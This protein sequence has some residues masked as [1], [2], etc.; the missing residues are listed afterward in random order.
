MK[1]LKKF[2]K[3]F[4]LNYSWIGIIIILIT[5]IADLKTSNQTLIQKTFIELFKTIGVSV[6]IASVFTWASESYEFIDKIQQLLKSVVVKRDF[7][8]N[9]D[10]ESKMDALK[11]IIKPSSFEKKIYANIEDYYDFYIRQTMEIANK[12]V[13]SDYS[14]NARIY[15][16]QVKNIIACDQT[17]NYRL[18]PNSNGYEKINV[19]FTESNSNLDLVQYVRVFKQ[20]NGV[21]EKK[22]ED[23]KLEE[24]MFEGMKVRICSID[25]SK[26]SEKE[27]HLIIEIKTLTHGY[28]HWM[29]NSIQALQPTD[30]LTFRVRCEDNI[31]IV[32]CDTFGQGVQ[33]NIDKSENNKELTASTFQWINEGT[34]ISI[35]TSRKQHN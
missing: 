20:N 17:I 4:F 3:R 8:S 16:D 5:I 28:D 22:G 18:Y 21:E 12:N 26:Y 7:L 33:F 1:S 27:K 32:N 10:S 23:I 19:G 2:L 14:I 34:G 35:I 24:K 31:E 9:L 29:S 30:G 15:F 6:L 13:R 11:S 25:L